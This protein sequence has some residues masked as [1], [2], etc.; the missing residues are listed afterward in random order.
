MEAGLFFS[1]TYEE[2]RTRFLET[3]IHAGGRLKTYENPLARG[4]RGSALCLDT[5]WFGPEDAEA[6]LFNIC[7]THGAEGYA[8]SA[9]QLAW[10][11]TC[12]PRDLPPRTA[13]LLVHAANPF[14]FA[15]GL[16]GTENNVDLNRN[17]LDHSLPHPENPL[18]DE[19]HKFLC[20]KRLDDQSMS[21]LVGAGARFVQK[22]GQ[23]ALEDAISRGQYTH[24]DGYHYGGL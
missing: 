18:Y 13:A 3:A 9:A 14:G 22:H 6:V 12:G 11:T 21:K 20:P 17:F 19:L 8:G 2:A 10:M 24:P 4:P 7:G 16:R 15:W 5:A 23:W 1:E